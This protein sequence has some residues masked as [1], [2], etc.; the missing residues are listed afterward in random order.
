M[1]RDGESDSED[2]VEEQPASA[3]ARYSLF[4]EGLHFANWPTGKN[5]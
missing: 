2:E 5:I 3:S 1:F 4:H